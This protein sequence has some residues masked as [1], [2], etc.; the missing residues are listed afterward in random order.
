MRT[1]NTMLTHWMVVTIGFAFP[2]T[3]TASA[4]TPVAAAIETVSATL[5]AGRGES[6]QRKI[7]VRAGSAFTVVVEGSSRCLSF[8]LRGPGG[9][10][11]LPRRRAPH[12]ISEKT[13]RESIWV[14]RWAG[15]EMVAEVQA[16][17][18]ASAKLTVTVYYDDGLRLVPQVAPEVWT[19]G[20]AFNLNACL[21]KLGVVV[22]GE[23]M[24][25]AA[26]ITTPDGKEAKAHLFDDGEHG[27]GRPNDGVFGR[28]VRTIDVGRHRIRF[29]A[30]YEI[31]G[32]HVERQAEAIYYAI[33]KEKRAYFVG[34]PTFRTLDYD[35]DGLFNS[36]SI[37]F[38]VHYPRGW[39]IAIHARLEDATGKVIKPDVTVMAMNMVAKQDHV[40][41]IGVESERIVGRAAD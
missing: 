35:G 23:S 4:G 13:W 37:E 15:G 3:D 28:S 1:L 32:K 5:Q 39:R 18:F 21:M 7:P 9:Q 8:D 36:L 20:K 12:W 31:D 14:S 25:L 34:P 2:A 24:E 10:S 41:T 30:K 11:L 22:V 40:I 17:H 16:G 29:Q 26:T 19:V 33:P 38:P 27:D 6:V